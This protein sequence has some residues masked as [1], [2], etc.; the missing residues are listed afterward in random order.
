MPIPYDVKC[1]GCGHT[2][3]VRV[4][5]LD[6]DGDLY[7]EVDPCESCIE[8]RACEM[9]ERYRKE[10]SGPDSITGCQDPGY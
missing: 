8:C 5:K 10:D 4:R 2:I 7:I 1:F 9:E 3:E 6:Y